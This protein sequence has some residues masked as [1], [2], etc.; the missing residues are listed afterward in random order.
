MKRNGFGFMIYEEMLGI[1]DEYKHLAEKLNLDYLDLVLHVG[2]DF[3]LVFTISEDNLKNLSIDYKVIGKV[4]DS[5][6]IEL[7][8]E[9]GLVVEIKNKGYEHYVSE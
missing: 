5:D 8:L 7:T 1:S 4:T 6:S 9:N 2:E 3:E